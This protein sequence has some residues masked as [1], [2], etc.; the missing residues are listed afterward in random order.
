MQKPSYDM[1]SIKQHHH[2]SVS[3]EYWGASIFT[4]R[5]VCLAQAE[6]T[7]QQS[8]SHLQVWFVFWIRV[9]KHDSARSSWLIQVS[10][11]T[12]L[13]R[14]NFHRCDEASKK[15]WCADPPPARCVQRA[16]SCISTTWLNHLERCIQGI[17]HWDDI[18]SLW[19]FVSV[20]LIVTR[21]HR[22][23]SMLQK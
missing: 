18:R 8:Y 16:L 6:H 2:G 4:I 15:P 17:W 19:V 21:R 11:A 22:C 23:S 5:A 12:G 13:N 7:M 1:C 14:S 10:H 9:V 20:T 3:L